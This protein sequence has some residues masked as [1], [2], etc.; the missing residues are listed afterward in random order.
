MRQIGFQDAAAQSF[1]RAS[2]LID[3]SDDGPHQL[4]HVERTTVGEVAFCQR[5]NALVGIEVGRVGWKVLDVQ[6]RVA[7]EELGE[8]RSGVR[9]GIVQQNDDRAAKVAQQFLEEEDDF[10]LPDVVEE[11]QVVEAQALSLGL[12]EIPEMTEILS[13]RP[14][15]WYRRGVAPWGAQVRTTKGARRKPDS[16][17]KTKWAPS[18]AAFFLP[19]ASL[20][21]SSVPPPP[22]PAR[23][24]AFRVSASSTGGHASTDRYDRDDNGRRTRAR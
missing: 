10:F 7:A 5:P 15:R 2:D 17:A 12:R 23:R 6:A 13:R 11:K 18:R 19:A 22:R 8:R 21:A 20:S 4:V 24:R 3:G 14:W 1:G 9:G 16:S